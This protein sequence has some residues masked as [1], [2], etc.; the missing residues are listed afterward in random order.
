MNNYLSKTEKKAIQEFKEKITRYFNEEIL[1]LKL[2]GSKARGDSREDSDIDILI[3]LKSYSRKKENYIIDL[4]VKL[5]FK[6]RVDIS[7]HIYSE[8]QFLQYKKIPSIFLQII[9]REA[10][11]L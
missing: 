8:K 2:F 10:I 9:E 6:Y 11:L 1:E 5:L 3:V 4:A 7:P